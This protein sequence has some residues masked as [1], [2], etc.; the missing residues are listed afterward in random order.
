M[1]IVTISKLKNRRNSKFLNQRREQ[2]FINAF[3]KFS[4]E[5]NTSTLAIISKDNTHHCIFQ[6]FCGKNAFAWGR[7]P[8]RAFY[9]MVNNFNL[10]YTK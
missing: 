4:E 5:N 1:R 9:N 8:R 7:N 2:I 3:N 6:S 10:K